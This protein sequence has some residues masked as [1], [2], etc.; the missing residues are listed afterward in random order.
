MNI[1]TGRTSRS[2]FFL[3]N[4]SLWVLVILLQL[5]AGPAYDKSSQNYG[6]A[7]LI[8]AIFSFV[9]GTILVIRRWHDL[10]KSGW[11]TLLFIVPILNLF[12]FVYLFFAPGE[13]KKNKYG[14]KPQSIHF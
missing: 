7:G 12:V 8:V 4:I 5:L 10:G 9:T 1:I 14:E 13:N 2:L 11:F 3:S 6:V